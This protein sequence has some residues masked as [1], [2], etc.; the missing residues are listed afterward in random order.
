[1]PE[2]KARMAKLGFQDGYADSATFR[3]QLTT[4][5]KRNGEIIRAAGIQPN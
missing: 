3:E 5:H 4:E 1:M 2:V